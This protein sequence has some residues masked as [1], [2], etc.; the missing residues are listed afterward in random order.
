[1]ITQ[2]I[3]CDHCG[4]ECSG[5]QYA[6]IGRW[7]EPKT[8]TFGKTIHGCSNEHLGIALAKMFGIG[9]SGEANELLDRKQRELTRLI[10]ANNVLS[11]DR[12]NM[13]ARVA[14]HEARTHTFDTLK[15]E[16][17][18]VQAR[19]RALEKRIAD[20][21]TPETADGKTPGPL[22]RVSAECNSR[23]TAYYVWLDLGTDDACK[24]ATGM[25][26]DHADKLAAKIN[27]HAFGNQG[28]QTESTNAAET[29]RRVM[30]RFVEESH[31]ASPVEVVRLHRVVDAE[32]ASLE[33]GPAD[34]APVCFLCGKGP[35]DHTMMTL[36]SLPEQFEVKW[37]NKRRQNFGNE[38]P[39]WWDKPTNDHAHE[40]TDPSKPTKPEEL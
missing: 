5:D 12:D 40:I 34:K 26:R 32:L 3:T 39:S 19:E 14:E 35:H 13:R 29:L 20:L 6:S 27:A 7:D 10:D 18:R 17:Q 11:I 33:A 30:A 15:V 38:R 1:M 4:T 36:E 31:G 24:I 8:S 16:L 22:A 2:K 25:S 37:C 28:G 21:T 9:I 23:D